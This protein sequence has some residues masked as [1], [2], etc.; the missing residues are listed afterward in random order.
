MVA[1]TSVCWSVLTLGFLSIIIVVIVVVVFF[2]FIF[3][4]IFNSAVHSQVF[5]FWSAPSTMMILW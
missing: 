2:F 4:I 3:F 5:K 1:A